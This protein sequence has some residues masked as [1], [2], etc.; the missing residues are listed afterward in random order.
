MPGQPGHP[1][2]IT[3]EV[4]RDQEGNPIT[5]ADRIVQ[6]IRAGNYIEAAAPLGGVDKRTAYHWLKTGAKAYAKDDAVRTDFERACMSFSHAVAKAQAEAEAEDVAQLA[7]LARGGLPQIVTTVKIVDGKEVE[8][9][10]KTE[11]TLPNDRVLTWRLERRFPDRWGRQ[12]VELTGPE[13]EAIPV[14]VRAT[15]LVEAIEELRRRQSE[16]ES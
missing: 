8:R 7:R 6:A 15:K 5:S 2:D 3:R 13:G 14:E 1:S 9:T 16:E 11:A 4:G 12:R 10:T